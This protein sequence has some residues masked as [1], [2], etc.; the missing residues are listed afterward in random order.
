M[1]TRQNI[2]RKNHGKSKYT[3][4]KLVILGALS[5]LTSLGCLKGSRTAEK[6][7][8]KP[9]RAV[10]T[11]GDMRFNP[12][13]SNSDSILTNAPATQANT[14][15]NQLFQ[16]L[17]AVAPTNMPTN[18]LW[19]YTSTLQTLSTNAQNICTAVGMSQ[20]NFVHFLNMAQT[21]PTNE[22]ANV[23]SGTNT[24]FSFEPLKQALQNP[25]NTFA[26]AQTAFEQSA[27]YQVFQD[28]EQDLPVHEGQ[29]YFVY[30]CNA[31]D[32]N[33]DPNGQ[34]TTGVGLNLAR[35]TSILRQLRL[36]NS[37][38]VQEI[39]HP[40]P[41]ER[42]DDE[43]I[44]LSPRELERLTKHARKHYHNY[45]ADSFQEIYH[46]DVHPDDRHILDEYFY[47]VLSRTIR[48]T[49]AEFET[50][51]LTYPEFTDGS[52]LFGSYTNP[53]L[54]AAEVP[55]DIKFN[56]GNN[57]AESWKRFCR[58]YI[59]RNFSMAKR[60]CHVKKEPDQRRRWKDGLLDEA[61]RQQNRHNAQQAQA[62]AS[63]NSQLGQ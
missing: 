16:S 19:L 8:S 57:L 46:L 38:L 1:G 49:E 42:T 41:N 13:A 9:A 30:W 6:D 61:Q 28:L 51:R 50:L 24:L 47:D 12:F 59:N 2:R 63:R 39:I 3:A 35:R 52:P 25:T 36:K 33:G 21:I 45:K 22:L 48:T 18:T 23:V 11:A 31:T 5:A 43:Y 17:A 10:A 27:R 55:C 34:P 14:I 40:N 60:E 15:S 32:E 37:T 58:H 56:T 29:K 7:S 62:A 4:A 54:E 53:H 20:T 44:H 26:F